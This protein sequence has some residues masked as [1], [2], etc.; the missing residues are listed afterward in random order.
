MAGNVT[1]GASRNSFW[2]I[3]TDHTSIGTSPVFTFPQTVSTAVTR[4]ENGGYD[5]TLDQ[6]EDS[7][8]LYT[9]LSTYAPVSETG[10]QEEVTLEDGTEV[11]GATGQS[12]DVLSIVYGAV[13]SSESKRKLL[14]VIC[15]L[16][17][18]SGS[19]TQ[20]ANTYNRPTLSALAQKALATVTVPAT[21]FDSTLVT[22]TEV[23]IAPNTRGTVVWMAEA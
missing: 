1:G 12:P 8:A 5:Y 2:T 19:W 10:A 17:N 9:F 7:E 21:Y 11:G 22:Q 14:V 23:V 15:K 13:N 6:I 20:S 4:N 3:A 16:D 18:T